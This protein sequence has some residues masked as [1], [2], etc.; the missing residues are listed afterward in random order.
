MED[1]EEVAG[2][3]VHC[4]ALKKDGS[5]WAWGNPSSG[6]LGI[7][8]PAARSQANYSPQKLHKFWPASETIVGIGCGAEVSWAITCTGDLYTWGRG[9]GV[10][11][12]TNQD[13]PNKKGIIVYLPKDSYRDQ[14]EIIF[15]W[16]FLGRLDRRSLFQDLPLEVMFNAV[17]VWNQKF[18]GQRILR[19]RREGEESVDTEEAYQGKDRE[20]KD[21]RKKKGRV[22][23]LIKR[24]GKK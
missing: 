13:R 8:N 23:R 21:K 1:V 16:F 5:L 24:T 9:E 20:K 15:R 17:C 22:S 11:P 19:E 10:L 2:G 12:Y 18:H 4:L 7:V 3:D 6:Q 14:W